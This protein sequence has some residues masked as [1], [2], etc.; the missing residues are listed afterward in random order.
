MAFFVDEDNVVFCNCL[1]PNTLTERKAGENAFVC[2]ECDRAV[3]A[4]E[5]EEKII[6]ESE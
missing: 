2:P 1:T 6:P 5:I 3:A 4:I